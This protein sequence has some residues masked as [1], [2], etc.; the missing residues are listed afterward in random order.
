[1]K[2]YQRPVTLI[3]LALFTMIF[4]FGFSAG[5]AAVMESKEKK[6]QTLTVES[7]EKLIELIESSLKINDTKRLAQ[8]KTL[9]TQLVADNKRFIIRQCGTLLDKAIKEE[10]AGEKTKANS[11]FQV[12]RILAEIYRDAAKSSYL[13]DKV[14]FLQGLSREKKE[15]YLKAEELFD[16][17][18]NLRSE[19]KYD[20]A[21]DCCGKSKYLYQ[22]INFKEG[23]ANSILCIGMIQSRQDKKNKARKYY[24]IAL[25][26]C[27]TIKFRLGEANSLY[28]LGRIYL[29]SNDLTKAQEVYMESLTIYREIKD[30]NGEANCLKNLGDIYKYQAMYDKARQRYEEAMY[31]FREIKN[32]LGE[33]QSLGALGDMYRLLSDLKKSRTYYEEALFIFREIK[34]RLEEANT[35]HRLGDMYRILSDYDTALQFY[36]QAIVIFRAIK[37]RRGEANTLKSL[38]D[39]YLRLNK[40]KKAQ[41]FLEQAIV[42]FRDIKARYSEAATLISLGMVHGGISDYG[43]SLKYYQQALLIAREIKNRL[44]EAYSLWRLGEVHRVSDY[45]EKALLFYERALVIF[46]KIRGR[47]GEANTILGLGNTNRLLYHNDKAKIFYEQALEIYQEIK[48]PL[49][50]ANALFGLGDVHWMLTGY[51]KARQ[52][53]ELAILIYRKIEH[54]LGEANALWSLGEMNTALAN[55]D[56][57]IR[58]YNQGLEIYRKIKNRLGEAN[59]LQRIGKFYISLANYEKARRHCEQALSIYREIK[60]RL[61]EA[62]SLYRLGEIHMISGDYDKA[63]KFIREGRVIYREIKNHIGEAI[64]LTGLGYLYFRLNNY[65]KARQCHEEALPIY[66]KFKHSL[67]VADSLQRLGDVHYRLA[68][69]GKARQ[70]YKEAIY[71]QKQIGDKNGILFSYYGMGKILEGIQQY[72]AAEENYMNSIQAIEE[73][74]Q[75]MKLESYKIRYFSSNVEP[76]EALIALLFNQN[77]GEMAFSY[78]ERSKARTFLYLIGNK[79]INPKTGVSPKLV[80]EEEEL[81]QKITAMTSKIMKNEEKEKKKRAPSEKLKAE[82]LRLKERHTEIIETIK[83]QSPEYASLKTVNPLPNEEIQ[84]LIRQDNNTVLIEYYITEKAIYMWLLDGQQLYPYKIDISRKELQSSIE[85]FGKLLT[86]SASKLTT[87]A[88]ISRKLYNLLLKPVEKHI[89]GK[90]RIA[91]VPHGSLHYLPF[92]TLVDKGKFLVEQGVS[93]FYLPSASVYKYCRDKNSLKK[94]YLMAIGNPDGTLPLS[95]NEVKAISNLYVKNAKIFIGKDAKESTIKKNA[96]RPD[97]LHFACHGRFNSKHPMYSALILAPDTSDDGRLEVSEIFNLKLK[98]AYLVTLS[99][100]DTNMGK[101]YHGDEIV[102]LSRAFIYAGTPS[103]VTSLW[104]VDDYYTMEFM[105]IFYRAL[106]TNDKIDALNIARKAII[107][108]HGKRHPFY[109]AAFVLIGDPR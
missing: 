1:M 83:L 38:G 66:R 15:K 86:D 29:L 72:S 98:P 14:S 63:Q 13:L 106:K 44:L 46:R 40:P 21:G 24:E 36:E 33:A 57:A 58:F 52:S 10:L 81:R 28:L 4:V 94:K 22:E 17:G 55:Y 109:W 47:L 78:S 93:F 82:L 80:N 39:L 34:E 87:L 32:Q 108:N 75:Q 105:S 25:S 60:L 43:K 79:K 92:E 23:V 101:I 64:S 59:A 56:N 65:K 6:D 70:F 48:H 91:V 50:E 95:E 45:Y 84:T 9:N 27:R 90:S 77:K 96:S 31:I 18:E 104:D 97:L 89:H 5:E 54:P 71:L 3:I 8:I 11:I 76:Y 102:G 100:C 74:W 67:G 20:Q 73:I 42:I 51:E 88:R 26:I 68:D 19:H 41:R 99:A 85:Y 53:Y 107:Q 16:K 61:G 62:D 2:Q 35:L 12:C 37:N 69:Y 30:R 7:V 49:G 103:I